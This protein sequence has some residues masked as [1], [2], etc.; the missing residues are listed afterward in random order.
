MQSGDV[1]F[2]VGPPPPE[3]VV[4]VGAPVSIGSPPTSEPVAS[5]QARKMRGAR[6][7]GTAWS[8][9]QAARTPFSTGGAS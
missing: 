4:V 9:V 8:F 3:G 5:E 2:V 1:T 7:T 6:R